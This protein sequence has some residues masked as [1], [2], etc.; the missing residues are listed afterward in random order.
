MEGGSTGLFLLPM[1]ILICVGKY[2]RVADLFLLSRTCKRLNGMFCFNNA[3]AVVR[4]LCRHDR[5]SI[6]GLLMKDAANRINVE[7]FVACHSAV[8]LEIASEE[9]IKDSW[10]ECRSRRHGRRWLYRC[11]AISCDVEHGWWSTC[12]GCLF[13]HEAVE[14]GM[15]E[16]DSTLICSL[17]VEY[18]KGYGIEELNYE[19][20]S[21]SRAHL[22]LNHCGL[23][24]DDL[25]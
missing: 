25:G 17:A 7:P 13:V 23:C 6:S 8:A 5:L 9:F 12:Y 1:E 19:M 21:F 24:G 4:S 18:M 14:H 2:L 3:E 22:Y 10:S 15:H 20:V 11:L 16:G